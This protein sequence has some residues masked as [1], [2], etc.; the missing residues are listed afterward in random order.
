MCDLGF[1]S[2]LLTALDR[3]SIRS[4]GAVVAALAATLTELWKWQEAV[5][6]FART[7]SPYS[8]CRTLITKDEY[9]GK[10]TLRALQSF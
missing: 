5:A 9:F 6:L 2:S 8:A 7:H 10:F 4:L 3:S 1:E